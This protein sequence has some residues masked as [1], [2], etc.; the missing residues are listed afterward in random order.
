MIVKNEED[1]LARCLASIHNVVDEII[2]VDTGSVDQTKKIA[3]Q[4]TK[5]IYD[6]KWID[7]FSA[8]RNYS[9]Q[10][11]TKD[12]TM[13]LDADD[14]L[15]ERNRELLQQLKVKLNK[16][17]NSV[18][19]EY[20]VNPQN[21]DSSFC[22]L[23]R[24]R[25]V[26]TNCKFKWKGSV[27]EYLDVF[28]PI[29]HSDIC[30]HHRK[31][32]NEST[33]RN[34]LIY[35]KQLQNGEVLTPRDLFY[36]ANELY[37]HNS[38]KKA[39]DYYNL[40][41]KNENGWKEDKITACSRLADCYNQLGDRKK[42]KKSILKSFDY[43]QPRAEFCCRLGQYYLNKSKLKKAIFWYGFATI[44]KWDHKSMG[45][46]HVPSWTWLPHKQLGLCYYR[47]GNLK[48]AIEHNSAALRYLPNDKRIIKLQKHLERKVNKKNSRL[49]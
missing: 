32:K 36:Y 14:I 2:V 26:K 44:L 38:I 16:S 46:Y 29:Y 9:F 37:L 45:F 34:L 15:D 27:H 31:L 6:F 41:L 19:M 49:Y 13:W 1:T 35:E 11:A 3:G 10:F 17:V 21:E 22:K 20:L 40:F 8:A 7:N 39:I 4:F 42:E 18:T 23:R 30:I 33:L 48:K 5:N 12:Y 25:L 28:G 47:L 24:N 43:D